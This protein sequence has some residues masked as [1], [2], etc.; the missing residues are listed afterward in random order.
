MVA[1]GAAK[2]A[3]EGEAGHTLSERLILSSVSCIGFVMRRKRRAARSCALLLALRIMGH[4]IGSGNWARRRVVHCG[5]ETA[6]HVGKRH[7]AERAQGSV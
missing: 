5:A 4:E 2:A 7:S 1:E 3:L 6:R